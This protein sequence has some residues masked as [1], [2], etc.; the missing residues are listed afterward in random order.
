M[1]CM[2]R[3]KRRIKKNQVHSDPHEKLKKKKEDHEKVDAKFMDKF[4]ISVINSF[5]VV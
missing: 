5:I 1:S 4:V 2:K 3:G